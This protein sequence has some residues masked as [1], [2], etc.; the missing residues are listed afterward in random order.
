M[1]DLLRKK[2]SP[3]LSEC[4]EEI[5][6]RAMLTVGLIGCTLVVLMDLIVT[7]NLS[8]II[9]ANLAMVVV[10]LVSLYAIRRLKFHK[11][12]LY[13]VALLN[14]II[15]VR[16]FV[17]PEFHHVTCILLI[18]VGFM[19]ALVRQGRM[20]QVMQ[21]GILVSFIAFLFRDSRQVAMVVLIRGAVPYLVVYFIITILSGLLKERY[22]WNQN[23]LTELVALLNQKNAKI[24]EQHARLQASYKELSDLNNY[25]EVIIKQKTSHIAEK[26][27]QLA[28]LSYE[29]SHSLRAPLARMLGLLHLIQVDPERKDFY[30]S[31]LDDQALE[32]DHRIYMVSKSIE[33]NLHE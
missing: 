12:A 10:L 33:R 28:Q 4:I 18:T 2:K 16:G 8:Y 5:F 9:P 1:I 11:A 22:T 30:L 23:R 31:K 29:N 6:F 19:C 26:N 13:G 27:K 20:G 32:M 17:Y 14:I 24:N 7:R 3:N 21:W 25:Q 15:T